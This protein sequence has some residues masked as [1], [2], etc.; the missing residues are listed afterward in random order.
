MPGDVYDINVILNPAAPE[1]IL[2]TVRAPGD[3]VPNGG[4]TGQTIQKTSL[5]DGAVAWSDIVLTGDPLSPPSSLGVGQLL[6]DGT[7]VTP[8]DSVISARLSISASTTSIANTTSTAL[9]WDVRTGES[10]LWDVAN[11]TRLV[12]PTTGLYLIS[13]T[14]RFDPAGGAGAYACWFR[15]N[16]G[17]ERFASVETSKLAGAVATMNISTVMPMMAGDY[18][19]FVV[20]HSSG[21]AANIN[22][23]A[24][25]PLV[26]SATITRLA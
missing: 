8:Q 10:V 21:A 14:A 1:E 3:G 15:K 17:S 19:T 7:P 16:A 25:V 18:V 5:V 13:G 12:A 23:D 11:P 24:V 20:Y 6:W 26:T 9:S 22:G 4:T 2:V